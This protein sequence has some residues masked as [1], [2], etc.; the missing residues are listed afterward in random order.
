MI[1]SPNSRSL[2]KRF[3]QTCSEHGIVHN[4]EQIFRYLSV[5][6]EKQGA[7]QMSLWDI[8]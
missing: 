4:N 5:F 1:E 7:R 6:E 8:L 3:H 2:M